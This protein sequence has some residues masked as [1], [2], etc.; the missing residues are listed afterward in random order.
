VVSIVEG[1]QRDK[2]LALP[3]FIEIASY[4]SDV[5]KKYAPFE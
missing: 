4:F 1:T 3:A 5:R 2:D